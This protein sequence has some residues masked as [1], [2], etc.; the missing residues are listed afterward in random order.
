M[1]LD[2]MIR[3]KVSLRMPLCLPSLVLV[4]ESGSPLVVDWSCV[5]VCW[6]INAVLITPRLTLTPIN[7]N[8]TFRLL[9]AYFLNIGCSLVGNGLL[10]TRMHIHSP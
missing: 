8:Q 9:R 2:G 5:C 10:Y 1:R 6:S 4:A 7:V 3:S